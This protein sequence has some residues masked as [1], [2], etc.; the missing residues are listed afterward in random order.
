V[1]HGIAFTGHAMNGLRHDVPLVR[2]RS[3]AGTIDTVDQ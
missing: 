2:W 3:V 1:S